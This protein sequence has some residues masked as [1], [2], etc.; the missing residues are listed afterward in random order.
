MSENPIWIITEIRLDR[1]K[2]RERRIEIRIYLDFVLLSK[3][4]LFVS[5]FFLIASKN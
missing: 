1:Y 2:E 3:N 4:E 5:F